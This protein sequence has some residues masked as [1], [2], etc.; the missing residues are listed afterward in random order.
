MWNFYYYVL[1]FFSTTN[2]FALLQILDINW[3]SSNFHDSG[4]LLLG[5]LGT[6]EKQK[7]TT[8]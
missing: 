6:Q 2:L 8:E 4:V 5:G 3:G 1:T 7:G